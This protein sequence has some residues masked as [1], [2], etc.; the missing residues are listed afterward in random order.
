MDCEEED[1]RVDLASVAFGT[2]ASE[3]PS[4]AL[5]S[6]PPPANASPIWSVGNV[7]SWGWTM[8]SL[9]LCLCVSVDGTICDRDVQ[10]EKPS[11]IRPFIRCISY[12]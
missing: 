4:V 5:L 8:E 7:D 10:L 6:T 3:L 9:K 12:Q 2:S 1:V 11:P